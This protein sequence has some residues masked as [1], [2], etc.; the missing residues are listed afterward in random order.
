MSFLRE[1]GV[2]DVAEVE[3]AYL[4]TDGRISV[5]TRREGSR[6]VPDKQPVKSPLRARSGRRRVLEPGSSPVTTCQAAWPVL[7]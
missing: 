6:G 5:I 7:L 4:E 3:K 1:Q 2:E